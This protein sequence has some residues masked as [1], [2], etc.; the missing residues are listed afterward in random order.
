MA[1]GQ[2]G[3]EIGHVASRACGHQQKAQRNTG[4]R[5]P[6]VDEIHGQ[7]REEEPLGSETCKDGFRVLRDPP[8]I[9]TPDIERHTKHDDAQAKIHQPFLVVTKMDSNTVDVDEHIGGKGT[10]ES[11]CGRRGHSIII[12]TSG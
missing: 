8:E 9:F 1:A 12:L 10:A 11:L 2:V 3:Q 4:V 5:I 6:D 7:D